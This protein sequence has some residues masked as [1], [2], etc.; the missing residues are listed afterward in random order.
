MVQYQKTPMGVGV[1]LNEQNLHQ[2]TGLRNAQLEVVL[3][4]NVVGIVGPSTIGANDA[5]SDFGTFPAVGLSADVGSTWNSTMMVPMTPSLFLWPVPISAALPADVKF[6]VKA[7]GKD[8]FGEAIEEVTPWLSTTLTTTSLFRVLT[9]SKVFAVVD[10]VYVATQGVSSL[11]GASKAAVGWHTMIDPTRAAAANIA[12]TGFHGGGLWTILGSAG[13]NVDMMGTWANYGF[14]TTHLHTP[15]GP[16]VPFPSPEIM[17]AQG[18]VLRQKTTPTVIN[19]TAFLPAR[20]QLVV[21]GA[22]PVTGV[23]IGGNL[24]GWQGSPHKFGFFSNDNWTT[25][26]ANIELGGSSL[27][28]SDVP[29]TDV[30]LGE[31]DMQFTALLHTWVSTARGTSPKKSYLD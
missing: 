19:E 4:T 2:S 16:N 9:L 1:G 6:K 31:D 8:Q 29:T 22:A 20:G 24:A 5:P 10:E 27:R 21:A 3:T 23:R 13:S 28:A 25:K 15:Y 18:T 30:M 17:G 7:R 11:A 14:G 26:I 12:F